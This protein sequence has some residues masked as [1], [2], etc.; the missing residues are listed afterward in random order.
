MTTMRTL[1]LATVTLGLAGSTVMAAQAPRAAS[2]DVP[3]GATAPAPV[4]LALKAAPTLEQ[5]RAAPRRGRPV[6]LA[7]KAPPM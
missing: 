1:L 4:L 6:L 3:P 7:L 5:R 2:A